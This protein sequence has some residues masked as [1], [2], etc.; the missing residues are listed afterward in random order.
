MKWSLILFLGFACLALGCQD[1]ENHK[2]EKGPFAAAFQRPIASSY[3]FTG[4]LGGLSIDM[5]CENQGEEFTGALNFRDTGVER[6]FTGKLSYEGFFKI[7]A[8]AHPS[9]SALSR[10]PS[11]GKGIFLTPNHIVGMWQSPLYDKPDFFSVTGS[12][13]GVALFG[14]E[15]SNP[16]AITL[17]S[18]PRKVHC[19][20]QNKDSTGVLLVDVPQLEVHSFD[21]S[22]RG[23]YWSLVRSLIFTPRCTCKSLT[24][25]G[26]GTLH[27][28][29]ESP[30]LTATALA[31]DLV[32]TLAGRETQR[33]QLKINLETGELLP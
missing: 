3:A 33:K 29:V 12:S 28:W 32:E 9:D 21:H 22:W 4:E 25:R 30:E 10:L 19:I 2:D 31:V 20:A 6:L 11:K 7:E 16:Q 5:T 26:G 8:K 14:I 1:V 13:G 18:W 27:R 17:N 24:K 15:A 23:V